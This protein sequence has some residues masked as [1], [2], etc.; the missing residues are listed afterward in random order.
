MP[1]K[2]SY[3]DK[4][5]HVSLPPEMRPLLDQAQK[6]LGKS[7]WTATVQVLLENFVQ[8]D[9]GL[10]AWFFAKREGLAT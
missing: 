10:A 5:A 3:Q 1:Q 2:S 7:S 8:P 6:K 4:K 9:N